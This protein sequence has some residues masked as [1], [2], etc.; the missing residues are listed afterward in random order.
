MPWA[1]FLDFLKAIWPSISAAL[2]MAVT[3]WAG[4]A[5]ADGARS[6]QDVQR[7]QDAQNRV[8]SNLKRD[9]DE[10]LRDAERRGLYRL[11]DKPSDDQP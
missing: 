9:S 2:K 11:P 8:S 4:K 1:V 3:A 7:V 6:K 10:R 5:L